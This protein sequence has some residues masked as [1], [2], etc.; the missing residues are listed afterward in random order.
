MNHVMCVALWKIVTPRC[1]KK[2]SDSL[3][4]GVAAAAACVFSL[5]TMF[6][7]NIQVVWFIFVVLII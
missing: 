1:Q 5:Y 7:C 4:L 6:I 2:R 3:L